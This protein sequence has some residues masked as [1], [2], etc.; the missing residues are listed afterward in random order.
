MKNQTAQKKPQEK[1]RVMTAGQMKEIISALVESIPSNLSFEVAE[2]IVG[3]KGGLS[4]KVKSI[5]T[6]MIANSYA[7]VL[8]DWEHFYFK[9]FQRAC[10]F[11]LLIVPPCPSEKWRLLVIVDLTIEQLYAKCKELFPCWRW[12][13]EDF[14][15]IVIQN[16]RDA[17]D[18]T[19][20]IWVKS[21]VEA[22]E[23]LKNLSANDIKEKS[24]TTETLAERLI[25]EL[26]FFAETGKH[27][28]V[29]NVTLCA[30]S[31]YSGG[32][33]SGVYWN[34]SNM[35]VTRYDPDFQHDYLRSR[36]AV[37]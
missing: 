29:N 12:T 3:S 31:R 5:F 14:D 32:G 17:K 19:Y 7:D 26:K 37:S 28:D 4:K 2:Q 34:D 15:K 33:V 27:L 11:S 10:D 1:P 20:A 23:N 21:D 9:Y 30:D 18:G 35:S 22:D 16:E 24:I 13:D 36:Q 6:S 8:L 25:H